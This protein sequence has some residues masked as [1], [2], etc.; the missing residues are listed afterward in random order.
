[1][2]VATPEVTA[3]DLIRFAESAGHLSHVATLLSELAEK[4][5]ADELLKVAPIYATTDVQ[6][7]GYL[8]EW[9]RKPKLYLPLSNWLSE[10][11][12]RAVAL[13]P[14][15]SVKKH[16]PDARWKVLPNQEIEIDT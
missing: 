13:S 4:I 9:L 15:H 8:L 10:Q 11:P 14:S 2:R 3:L 1:M 16:V 12:H 7:L 6:R 5:D